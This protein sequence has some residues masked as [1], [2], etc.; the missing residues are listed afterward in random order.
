MQNSTT[1]TDGGDSADGAVNATVDAADAS[2]AA[3]NSTGNATVNATAPV[4]VMKK[5]VHRFPLKI[6]ADWTEL[7]VSPLSERQ[8]NKALRT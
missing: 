1:P 3:A 5:V 8:W 2:D 6:V 7:A 4:K